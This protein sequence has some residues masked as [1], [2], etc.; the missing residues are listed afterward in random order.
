MDTSQSS[1]MQFTVREGALLAAILGKSRHLVAEVVKSYRVPFTCIH[2]YT[3]SGIVNHYNIQVQKSKDKQYCVLK[4]CAVNKSLLY[5]YDYSRR[6]NL[7][8]PGEIIYFFSTKHARPGYKMFLEFRSVYHDLIVTLTPVHCA[9]TQ[10]DN[11]F[12]L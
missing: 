6:S 9:I 5:I 1:Q 12:Y 7:Q 2:I 11:T 8:N 4:G 3:G 10:Y